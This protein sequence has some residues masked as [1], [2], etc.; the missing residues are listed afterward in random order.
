MSW[1]AWWDFFFV[2]LQKCA[3]M[4]RKVCV[5]AAVLSVTNRIRPHIK[6]TDHQENTDSERQLTQS[7][8][9]TMI[10]TTIRRFTALRPFTGHQKEVCFQTYCKY[11]GALLQRRV[12]MSQTALKKSFTDGKI[13]LSIQWIHLLL[14][15]CP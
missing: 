11:F 2:H 13:I 6:C 14:K 8:V 5:S 12:L 9:N 3:E 7:Q 10:I 15:N 4:F 1:H